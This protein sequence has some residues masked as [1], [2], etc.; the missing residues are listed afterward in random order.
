MDAQVIE[1]PPRHP[2]DKSANLT[3][4]Q[5]GSEW[6]TTAGMTVDG[7]TGQPTGYTYPLTCTECGTEIQPWT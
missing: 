1:F 3:C 2:S 4:L 7:A 5:C 6:W